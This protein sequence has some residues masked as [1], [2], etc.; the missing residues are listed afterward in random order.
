MQ[1]QYKDKAT[2]LAALHN[3]ENDAYEYLYRQYFNSV[4]SLVLKNKGS[5]DD[6]R[7]LFQE[8]LIAFFKKIRNDNQFNLSVEIGTYLYAIARNLWLTELKKTQYNKEVQIIDIQTFAEHIPAID[9]S[10]EQQILEEKYEKI[11]TLLNA[12]KQDCQDII[13]AAFYERL[14]GTA[15]AKKLGY[16]EDFVKVKKF[17]CL[18][19]LRKKASFFNYER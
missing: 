4:L 17:R 2:L 11:K 6:A 13:N 15:I 19:E 1:V 14:S 8:T 9:L 12:M 7:E 10:E 5:H 18:E 16:T 3:R